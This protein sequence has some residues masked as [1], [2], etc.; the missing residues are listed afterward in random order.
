MNN[1]AERRARSDDR[2]RKHAPPVEVVR[3]DGD[4]GNVEQPGAD[5]CTDP[6]A[7]EDLTRVS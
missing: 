4:G 5:A 2:H 6:L 7:K 3:D 1:G